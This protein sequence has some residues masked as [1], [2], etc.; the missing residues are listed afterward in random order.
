M[1]GIYCIKVNDCIVYIGK[2][3]D[4]QHRMREHWS[5]IYCPNSENKYQ[6]L[7]SAFKNYNNITFWVLGEYDAAELNTQ[8][9]EWIKLLKP[10]LNDKLNNGIGKSLTTQDFF[11]EIYSRS[12]EVDGMYQLLPIEREYTEEIKKIISTLRR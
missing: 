5:K 9:K 10:C 12:D 3:N 1:I 7:H 6:L 4:L 2:S 8:E 11:N